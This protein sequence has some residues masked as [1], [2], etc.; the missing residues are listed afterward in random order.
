MKKF[1]QKIIAFHKDLMNANAPTSHRRY[2]AIVFAYSGIV[3]AFIGVGFHMGVTEEL[4]P[5]LST[6]LLFAG[7]T[8]LSS[9]AALKVKSDV[10]SEVVKNDAT[11]DTNQTAKEIIQSDKP[12]V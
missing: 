3:I 1:I 6:S 2:L 7:L 4:I 10:A 9:N 12:P 5:L 11:D 8:T